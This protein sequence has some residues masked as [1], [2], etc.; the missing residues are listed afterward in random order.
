MCT[1]MLYKWT[2][3]THTVLQ[4][5]YLSSTNQFPRLLA[6]YYSTLLLCHPVDIDPGP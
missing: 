5:L 2:Q 3:R 6:A 1:D 4:Y